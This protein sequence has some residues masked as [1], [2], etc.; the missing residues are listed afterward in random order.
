MKK[1]ICE[2]CGAKMS[3]HAIYQKGN[4]CDRCIDEAN[5]QREL[6]AVRETAVQ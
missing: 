6:Q 3:G 4:I 5:K 2:I 1:K